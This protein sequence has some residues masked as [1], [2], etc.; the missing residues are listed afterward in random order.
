MGYVSSFEARHWFSLCSDT[1][2][3]NVSGNTEVFICCVNIQV[4]I[5]HCGTNNHGNDPQQISEGIV[6]I[7]DELRRIFPSA[8]ILVWVGISVWIY[9]IGWVPYYD[10]GNLMLWIHLLQ[11][12]LPRGEKP[13]PV[14]GRNKKVN[15]IL[16]ENLDGRSQVELICSGDI[17]RLPDGLISRKDMYDYLHLTEQGYVK[18]FTP[19]LKRLQQILNAL[20]WDS[21]GG[22]GFDGKIQNIIIWAY[23]C[24]VDN[25]V[26]IDNDV[27]SFCF[28]LQNR[29][30][31]VGISRFIWWCIQNATMCVSMLKENKF[32]SYLVASV[33]E[34]HTE[35]VLFSSSIMS[36]LTSIENVNF[37]FFENITLFETG[38]IAQLWY[39]VLL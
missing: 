38:F 30:F 28:N 24:P 17:L 5:L 18:T 12:L 33:L 25:I 19:V 13:N 29:A 27:N 16:K 6:K 4:V 36:S 20:N 7:V 10:Y 11:G 32:C 3:I 21:I 9:R 26:D 8:F 37:S 39:S 14:C 35:L 22:C 15:E 31:I 1:G 2:R 23:E 34:W